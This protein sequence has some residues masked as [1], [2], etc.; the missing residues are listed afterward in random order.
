MSETDPLNPKL[1]ESQT[2][3]LEIDSESASLIDTP[4]VF[5]N[6]DVA[7]Y[8][9]KL[10]EASQYEGRHL[11]DPEFTWTEKEE[12]VLVRKADWKI[13]FWAFFMFVAL[14]LDRGNMS[15]ANAD[16]LL[17]D[18]K[19]TT[20]DMNLG[21]MINLLC[22]L[23]AEL[24]SQLI[25]KRIGP[26][27]WIPLQMLLWSVVGMSQAFL[28]NRTQYITCRALMGLLEGGFIPDICLWLSY[29]YKK[30]EMP[31]RMNLFYIANPLTSIL[32]SLLAFGI[33]RFRD[34]GDW[35]GWRWLFRR[36]FFLIEGG[37]T[38]VVGVISFFKMPASPYQTKAWFRKTP[39]FTHKEEKI[40]LNRLLR[41]E[42]AK[43]TMH[44]RE[45][46]TIKA[47][48]K[49]ASDYN[50]WPIYVIRYL[51]DMSTRPVGVYL[52]LTLRSLGF[53]PFITNLLTIPPSIMTIVW[54]PFTAWASERFKN[55]ALLYAIVPLWNIPCLVALRVWQG[56]LKDT[57][58]TYA[59]LVVT[60]S[61]PSI[62]GI[63]VSWC[64]ANSNSVKT[65]TVSA[66][67]VNMVSQ[68]AGISS[69]HIYRESDAPYYHRGNDILLLITIAGLVAC[70]FAKIYYVGVNRRRDEIWN[71]M[72]ERQRSYYTMNTKDEGSNRLDFRFTH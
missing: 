19:L 61:T 8:Y 36:W 29:F 47:T 70:I 44:N 64:S 71:S 62:I 39:Y 5:Q 6:P 59:L 54:F 67:L 63:S 46:L 14:D 42:P 1:N 66:A 4:H 72:T 51:T 11:F 27:V 69:S 43:G 60:L 58:G 13:T 34:E 57:W 2:S 3:V 21:N 10:Y 9:R 17:D 16:N 35:Q 45:A 7:D 18:L 15:Q 65:R 25:S 32:S 50:I 33:F 52:T 30:T 40:M 55:R 22:F 26:D 31:M 48:L 24:P 56:L 28:E 41:E 68:A 53:N 37:F 38:F 23:G 12:Q 49:A 20:D